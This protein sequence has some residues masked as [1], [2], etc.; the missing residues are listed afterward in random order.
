MNLGSIIRP[1]ELSPLKKIKFL[2]LVSG[3]P[4]S[5]FLFHLFC[6]LK[7]H[8]DLDFEVLHFNHNLRGDESDDEQRFVEKLCQDKGVVCHVESLHFLNQAGLQEKAREERYQRAIEKSRIHKCHALVTAHHR[9]DVL[10]T[11]VMR[12]QRGTGPLGL[13]G[14]LRW[15]QLKGKAVFRP[16]LEWSKDEILSYLQH[17][18][19]EYKTDS[20]NKTTKYLRNRVRQG[21]LL[22]WENDSQKQMV[23]CQSSLLQSLKE[24]WRFRKQGLLKKYRQHVPL[25]HWNRWPSILKFEFVKSRVRKLGYRQQLQDK[26]LKLLEQDQVKLQLGTCWIFKDHTGLYF[27]SQIQLDHLE[28][29][30]QIIKPEGQLYFGLWNK[31]LGLESNAAYPKTFSGKEW[32]LDLNQMK[33]PLTVTNVRAGDKIQAFGHRNPILL[34]DFMQSKGLGRY[35]RQFWPVLR[36]GDQV[37]F[38]W[39]LDTSAKYALQSQQDKILKLHC[40]RS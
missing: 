18:Q 8:E 38:V 16:L 31:A 39:G 25:L 2:L 24:Y 28:R 1:S 40:R 35:Q 32:Y 3:G 37:V 12:K 6:H 10:E 27:W 5:I 9:D 22:S 15:S 14:M 20:S 21:V 30:Q 34:T 19:L 7:H 33:G 13:A 4:D 29:Y 36:D 17:H 11:L 23:L 26:H